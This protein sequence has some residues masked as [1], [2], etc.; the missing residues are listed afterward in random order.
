VI[1]DELAE[2]HPHLYHVTD[3]RN[4]DGIRT[5][6]LLSTSRLLSLFEIPDADRLAIERR[7]RPKSV[8]LTHPVHGEA[9]ITDNVPLSEKA[10][11]SCL[12]D[13]L[14]PAD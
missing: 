11:M 10:L 8:P 2:K 13:G 6:G 14:V 3:P 7:S 5:H 9:I 12:D 4:W 1:P